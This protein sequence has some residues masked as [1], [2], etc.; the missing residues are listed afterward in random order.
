MKKLLIVLVCC[1]L[2]SASVFEQKRVLVFGGKTGWI[3]QK[4][5]ALL[6]AG[7]HEPVCATSRLENRQ[8]LID[9]IVRV[10]PDCIINAAGVTGKPTVDWCEEH[11]PE[12]LRAN[13]LGVLNLVDVASLFGLHVTNISTGCIY[14]YDEKHPMWSGIGFTE[15]D[16]PNFTG[17]FYSRNKIIMEKLI[18]AYPNVLNLRMKMPVSAELDKGFV[19]KIS[20]Y[21]KLVNIPNSLCILEDLLPI[22]VDMTL[23]GIKG[24][25]NF[26]NPGAMSHNQVM[27]LYKKYV[28]PTKTWENFTVE[29]QDAMLKARRANAELSAAKLLALYPGIPPVEESLSRLFEGIKFKK[30]S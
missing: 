1:Q 16:E 25:F 20:K 17:S 22:A 21:K 15:E 29:E 12:T 13:V 14:E 7:G 27:E 23:R 26:V 8:D 11:K 5:V 18:L 2:V 4:M 9:E 3:G 6:I 28:D 30:K 24:N 10:K 19:G